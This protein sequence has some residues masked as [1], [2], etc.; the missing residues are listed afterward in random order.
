IRSTPLHPIY[1]HQG[2]VVDLILSEQYTYVQ[3]SE[4]GDLYW[5]AGPVVKLEKGN[6]IG[7]SEGVL[8][9]GFY[10]KSLRRNFDKIL[11]V[12]QLAFIE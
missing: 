5:I 2:K 10:S 3:V 4:N 11:F 7:F 1:A 9:S 6:L 12:G 8:M